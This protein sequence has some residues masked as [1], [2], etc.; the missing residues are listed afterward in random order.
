MDAEKVE[1]VAFAKPTLKL[2]PFCGGKAD[3]LYYKHGSAY[4]SNIYYPSERGTVTC[5]KCHCSQHVF[6]KVKDAVNAWN[7]RTD[8]P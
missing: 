8:E 3:I 2:C 7:R 1:K 6:A 4:K 5:E